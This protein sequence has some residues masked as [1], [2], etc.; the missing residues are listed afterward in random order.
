MFLVSE[1]E[2]EIKLKSLCSLCSKPSTENVCVSCADI[3]S[4]DVILESRNIE[5]WK[6]FVVK[7]EKK[8][9]K[10]LEE[11]NLNSRNKLDTKQSRY[12]DK[13]QDTFDAIH[14]EKLKQIPIMKNGND[15]SLKVYYLHVLKVLQIL[16][17]VYGAF[18]VK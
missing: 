11:M 6:G 17:N 3:Q 5:N 13:N 7:D 12:F 15:M 16:K 1:S 10:V 4:V 9:R 2:K 18:H 8:E 14:F